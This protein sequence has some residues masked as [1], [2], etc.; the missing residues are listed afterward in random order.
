PHDITLDQALDLYAEKLK[1]EAEKNIADFGD[2]I[3]VLKGRYGPYITDGA[4]NA[5]I[6]KDVEPA[7]VTHE[8]AKELLASA[9]PAKGRFARKSTTKKAPVKKPAA[10]KKPTPAKKPATKKVTAARKPA[11]T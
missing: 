9:T 2:G 6:P 10:K 3:K 7:D 4:K 5:K 8:Q 1:T 11:S